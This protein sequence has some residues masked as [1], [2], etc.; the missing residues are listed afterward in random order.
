MI[1]IKILLYKGAIILIDLF[2]GSRKTLGVVLRSSIWVL[3]ISYM[4]YRAVFTRDNFFRGFAKQSIQHGPNFSALK[5]VDKLTKQN[6]SLSVYKSQK[7]L[8]GVCRFPKI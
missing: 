2:V 3:V 8:I 6:T 7:H 4:L 1:F 5:T